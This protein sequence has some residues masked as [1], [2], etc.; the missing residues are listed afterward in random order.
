MALPVRRQ[1]DARWCLPLLLLL[2]QFSGTSGHGM[3]LPTLR[4][5]LPTSINI[6]SLK[7]VPTLGGTIPRVGVLDFQVRRKE[8]KCSHALLSALDEGHDDSCF[9]FLLP[10]LPHSSG[11]HPETMSH[12]TPFL[13]YTPFLSYVASVVGFLS[14]QRAKKARK[15]RM[16][17]SVV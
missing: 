14:R 2:I 17:F 4:V 7:G 9:R 12:N 15:Y 5:A 1:R 8:A 3:V 13:P 10:R 6:N 16:P 11:L